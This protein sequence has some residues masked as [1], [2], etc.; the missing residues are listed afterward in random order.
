[1]AG[2][3]IKMR[4]GL[5]TK[6]PV[7]QIATA[8]NASMD[9]AVFMLYRLAEWFSDFGDYGVMDIQPK[10]IDSYLGADGVAEILLNHG[11]VRIENGRL[12]LHYF[13]NVSAVRKSIGKKLRAFVLS[14]GKCKKCGSESQLEIDHIIPVSKGGK[15]EVSN[16]QILCKQCNIKKGAKSDY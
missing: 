3:W 11:W 12:L 8:T 10:L 16:L 5:R 6:V 1:M 15:T 14:A 9:Q 4:K 7:V 13:T 2:D